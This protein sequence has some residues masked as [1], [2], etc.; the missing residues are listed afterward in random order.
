MSAVARRE[1]VFFRLFPLVISSSS[2]ATTTASSVGSV[3]ALDAIGSTCDAASAWVD[4][5]LRKREQSQ[6]AAVACK[7]GSPAHW[8]RSSNFEQGALQ[9]IF[10]TNVRTRRYMDRSVGYCYL[11]NEPA[12][13]FMNHSGYWEHVTHVCALYFSIAFKRQW[14]ADAVLMEAVALRRVRPRDAVQLIPS[15]CQSQITRNRVLAFSPATHQEM[16]QASQSAAAAVTTPSHPTPSP[17]P[18]SRDYVKSHSLRTNQPSSS[19][20]SHRCFEG[21]ARDALDAAL[22]FPNAA[23]WSRRTLCPCVLEPSA[24]KRRR[25]L[26]SLLWKLTE[27][28]VLT[29]SFCEIRDGSGGNGERMFRETVSCLSNQM[30]PPISAQAMT[31]WQQKAWG[32]QNLE[33]MFDLLNVGSVFQKGVFGGRVLPCVAETKDQKGAVMRQLVFELHCATDM[34]DAARR[35]ARE[36][37]RLDPVGGVADLLHVPPASVVGVLAE[38]TLQRLGFELLYLRSSMLMDSTAGGMWETLGF[39]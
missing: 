14:D 23:E 34:H 38:H 20:R 30:V 32:R 35:Q 37:D 13:N 26:L 5:W 19:H 8:S 18:P 1:K 4:V 17:V 16:V 29:F 12:Q 39:P 2:S 6:L 7:E 25:D 21:A 11:C 28:K 24:M 31:R 27:Y 10:C 36:E 33:V 9:N 15:F 3:S 22:C